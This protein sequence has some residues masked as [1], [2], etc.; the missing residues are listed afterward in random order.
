MSTITPAGRNGI[1]LLLKDMSVRN[2]SSKNTSSVFLS[3]VEDIDI[4][5]SAEKL[6][7]S[8]SQTRHAYEL[9]DKMATQGLPESINRLNPPGLGKDVKNMLGILYKDVQPEDEATFN[10]VFRAFEK[11]YTTLNR[12]DEV[13]EEL[14]FLFSK[15]APLALEKHMSSYAEHCRNIWR[16]HHF[17]HDENTPD[18]DIFLP[19]LHAWVDVMNSQ[20]AELSQ[21]KQSWSTILSTG[22]FFKHVCTSLPKALKFHEINQDTQQSA[23]QKNVN[24]IKTPEN[25]GVFIPAANDHGP[26]TINNTLH[27]GNSPSS[28]NDH[29]AQSRTSSID[30][31]GIAL[32]ATPDDQLGNEKVRLIDKYMDLYFRH[33]HN[34][35]LEQFTAHVGRVFP[36]KKP[37]FASISTPFL[38]AVVVTPKN[39]IE[40]DDRLQQAEWESQLLKQNVLQPAQDIAMEPLSMNHEDAVN[41]TDNIMRKD[42]YL[43]LEDEIKALQRDDSSLIPQTDSGKNLQHAAEQVTRTLSDLLTE[44]IAAQTSTHS[45]AN[46]TLDDFSRRVDEQELDQKSVVLPDIDPISGK[47]FVRRLIQKF[48]Q[49]NREQRI[50]TDNAISRN[51]ISRVNTTFNNTQQPLKSH[52][53]ELKFQPLKMTSSWFREGYNRKKNYTTYKTINLFDYRDHV[54]KPYG[55]A[56]LQEEE[57]ANHDMLED[58][59]DSL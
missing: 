30:D 12:E 11:S 15:Y 21:S 57:M 37:Q 36:D 16:Y 14:G 46:E 34:G 54:Q 41:N 27:N 40:L 49:L 59:V 47:G 32:L 50:H 42:V 1:D 35:G 51:N 55:S 2:K 45:V 18:S 23:D 31:F 29:S 53:D 20:I 43:E 28:I 22:C 24:E 8:P 58:V 39:T 48:E 33:A 7:K 25:T 19:A 4:Q 52:T 3:S 17:G 56:S 44:A 13:A 38:E 5:S 6:I 10:K 26:I 9:F